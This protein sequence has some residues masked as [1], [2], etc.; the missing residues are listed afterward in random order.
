MF[1]LA[2]GLNDRTLPDGATRANLESE[3]ETLYS[4]GAR[5]FMV[6]LLPTKIPAFS[7]VAIRLNPE[8]AKIPD[9]ERAKHP[10]I[11]IANSNWGPFFDAVLS[12]PAKYGFTDAATGCAQRTFGREP[13]KP[14]P[15]PDAHYYFHDSHPSTAAHKVVG[16]MLYQ[17]AITKA[18]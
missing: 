13:E 7:A 10:D 1:F 8:L 16:E 5:R 4:L 9:D 6:A 14:C 11:R 17:E 12:N 15:D 3:I 18:P 2:G